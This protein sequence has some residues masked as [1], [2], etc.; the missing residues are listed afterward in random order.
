V[1]QFFYTFLIFAS[2]SACERSGIKT[3]T[4]D[5]Q[6]TPIYI[7][8]VFSAPL[9]LDPAQMDD[10]SS[11][12]VSQLIYDGLLRFGPDLELHG[13]LAETWSTSTDGKTLHFKLKTNSYFHDGSR[14][15][16]RHVVK[17]LTRL[18][19][20]NS[21][22]FSY[23]DCIEGANELHAGRSKEVRGIRAIGKDQVEIQLRFPFP[24]FLSVLAGATAK[25]LP[26]SGLLPANFFDHP[27]GSGAFQFI[28][29]EKSKNNIDI[30]LKSFPGYYGI[31]PHIQKLIL[32]ASY[33]KTAL[34][35]AKN[36]LI[37]DLSNWPLLGSEEI[38]EKGQKIDS[39]SATTWIIGLNTRISPFDK[40]PI[41]RAFKDSIDTESFRK[42]FHP[43]AIAAKGYIPPGLPGFEW[44]Q[45]P[46]YFDPNRKAI[47]QTK[48]VVAIPKELERS[49]EMQIYLESQLRAKKWNIEVH[50][51]PWNEL[52]KG[53]SEKR[54]QSFLIGMNMDYPDTEFLVR[55]FESNNPDNFSG[56]HDGEIDSLIHRARST[57]DRVKRQQIYVQL[58]RKLKELAVTIDLFHPLGHFWIDSCVRGFVPNI[59]SDVYIDYRSIWLDSECQGKHESTS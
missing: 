34:R 46:N 37:N 10:A 54:F 26:S 22:V 5:P 35:N 20:P 4:N 30:T 29:T 45:T 24:P 19:A 33:E 49:R 55:N 59:L 56:I 28:K 9:T 44:S 40:L 39:P 15:E 21:K 11:L 6:Q 52:M 16:A 1:Q 48:I 57:Q 12:L 13:E 7:K 50:T 38:F 31:K 23:Y 58:V 32:R 53:Y 17:S 42:R 3:P 14:I 18:A 43:D 47:T 51:L 27:I 36:G 41:R 8:A 25:V 2:L